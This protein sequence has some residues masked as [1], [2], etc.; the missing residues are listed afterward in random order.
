M[1]QLI[2][3]EALVLLHQRLI[4]ALPISCMCMIAISCD[5]SHLADERTLHGRTDACCLP[6]PLQQR[7]PAH[8]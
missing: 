8:V 3:V 4:R 1:L 6:L 7:G 2:G 5:L